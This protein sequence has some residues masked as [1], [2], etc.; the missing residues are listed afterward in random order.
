MVFGSSP[1]NF[2]GICFEIENDVGGVF[3]NS[4]NR[5]ELVQNAFDLDRRDGRAFDRRKQHA[6]QRI[7]DG[8]SEPALERLRGELRVLIR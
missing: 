4:G 2:S 5:R 8:R 7:A 3:D 1:C 6:A